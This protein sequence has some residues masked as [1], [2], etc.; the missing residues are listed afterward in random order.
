M[1]QPK[2]RTVR[3][4]WR[5]ALAAAWL[6]ACLLPLPAHALGPGCQLDPSLAGN[7]A[8]DVGISYALGKLDDRGRMFVRANDP[9]YE[10]MIV[11]ENSRE[12]DL[13][14]NVCKNKKLTNVRSAGADEALTL[15]PPKRLTL[16]DALPEGS[17]GRHPRLTTSK[18][19]FS[20]ALAE[21]VA[22]RYREQ[23]A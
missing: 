1:I 13:N 4:G 19:E 21:L 23:V 15:I 11:G 7:Y 17:A 18:A 14:V 2:T 22:H 10:G 9:V 8:Q 6:A 5:G 16:E 3:R 20:A 12:N